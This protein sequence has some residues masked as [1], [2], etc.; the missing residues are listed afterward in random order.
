[1]KTPPDLSIDPTAKRVVKRPVPVQVHFAESDGIC[2]PLEG[3]VSFR[4]G[5]AVLTGVA[6]ETWPVE[7]EKFD[8]RY[9]PIEGV[10]S[11]ADGN[12]V[13]VRIEVMALRL[14]DAI[15]LPMPRGGTLHGEPG[16]WLVQHGM[17]DYGIVKASIF[18][19]TYDSGLY[20]R[21]VPFVSSNEFEKDN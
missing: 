13:K 6:G 8:E 5:D 1:M 21:G 17:H 18:L 4:A 20:L 2:Q 11:G 3:P 9:V 16:D 14:T 7:R 12:Y 15:D 19:V 10:S